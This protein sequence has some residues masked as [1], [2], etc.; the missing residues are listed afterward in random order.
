MFYCLLSL[1]LPSPNDS[2]KGE[3]AEKYVYKMSPD[4]LWMRTTISQSNDVRALT[5]IILSQND[6]SRSNIKTENQE[7]IQSFETALIE[8]V[9]SATFKKI[10]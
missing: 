2:V 3:S 1:P 4:T 10:T 8:S 9:K 5:N 6:H 7:L